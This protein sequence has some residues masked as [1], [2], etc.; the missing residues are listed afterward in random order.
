M[1]HDRPYKKAISKKK[2]IKEIDRLKGIQFDPDLS[3]K[4]I[5]IIFEEEFAGDFNNKEELLNFS[6]K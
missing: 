1:T 4:F 5:D 6:C 2:A 3:E